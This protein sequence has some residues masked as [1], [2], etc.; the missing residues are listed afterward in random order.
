MQFLSTNINKSLKLLGDKAGYCGDN[1]T[2]NRR[3]KQGISGI[4]FLLAL[5]EIKFVVLCVPFRYIRE[6]KLN[7]GFWPSLAPEGARGG[8]GMAGTGKASLE[9]VHSSRFSGPGSHH[10]F[11][12]G[13]RARREA[14]GP[15]VNGPK[16]GTSKRG[17]SS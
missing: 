3:I 1:S 12:C 2:D 11:V 16:G 17:H 8:G 5:E 9:E 13:I 7:L 15:K 4:N 14:N 10:H 6:V